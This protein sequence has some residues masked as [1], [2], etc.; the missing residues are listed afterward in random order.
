MDSRAYTED[1]K[2]KLKN[3]FALAGL[4]LLF[5]PQSSFAFLVFD[6][7]TFLAGNAIPVAMDVRSM[8]EITNDIEIDAA[9]TKRQLENKGDALKKVSV[10]V[11]AQHVVLTGVVEN[12][13]AKRKAVGLVGKDKRIRSL[14]NKIILGNTESGGNMLSNLFLEKKIGVTLSLAQGIHS[15]NMRWKATGG[16][17]VLMGVAKSQAEA[18]LAVSKIEVLEGVKNLK[19]CLRVNSKATD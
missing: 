12:E 15:V 5:L 10:L 17:V 7:I 9:A 19:S 2:M 18:N 16:Y 1:G 14:Q 6:P 11:F 4:F 13:E 3:K 8:S